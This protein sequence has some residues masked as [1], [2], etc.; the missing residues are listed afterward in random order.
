MCV[1]VSQQ[2]N[3][4]FLVRGSSRCALAHNKIN[5]SAISQLEQHLES[6]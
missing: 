2:M 1:E 5:S 4:K 6:K 3:G